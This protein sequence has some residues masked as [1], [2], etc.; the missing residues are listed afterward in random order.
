MP[1]YHAHGRHI[2]RIRI[3]INGVHALN[4][5]YVIDR[6]YQEIAGLVSCRF[7]FNTNNNNDDDDDDE[8]RMELLYDAR[9]LTRFELFSAM[10]RHGYAVHTDPDDEDVQS[11]LV[12]VQIRIE[13]MHC[14]SCVSNV[15]ATVG[16]LPG[17]VDIKLTFEEKLAAIVYD[18]RIVQ[19]EL[20]LR[21]I[22]GL[23]FK[24]AVAVSSHNEGS[25]R[26]N[27]R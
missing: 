19:L 22:N 23:G 1:V 14:N 16:E 10:Q 26:T 8:S 13:G 5:S 25:H 7:V 15:C 6:F 3:I 4:R 9:G 2:A 18:A 17:I 27:V 11:G 20:I 24:G 12:R 21:E